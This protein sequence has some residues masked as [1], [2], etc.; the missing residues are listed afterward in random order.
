MHQQ[1][2]C[3]LEGVMFLITC[4][5][6]QVFYCTPYGPKCVGSVLLKQVSGWRPGES[7]SDKAFLSPYG[8]FISFIIWI[9]IAFETFLTG[10]M[11]SLCNQNLWLCGGRLPVLDKVT[12]SK[13]CIPLYVTCW[14]GTIASL[15]ALRRNV[16]Y[17]SN[18][19]RVSGVNIYILIPGCFLFIL[20]AE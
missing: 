14:K 19:Y 7:C 15:G 10:S 3:V 6:G 20:L 1:C 2:V 11:P 17:K 8:I 5:Q 12:L 13:V 9:C 18:Q 4:V 16:E